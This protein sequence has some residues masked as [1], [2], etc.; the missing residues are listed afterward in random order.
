MLNPD[1]NEA[2]SQQ[3]YTLKKDM[4]RST[5]T[6]IGGQVTSI[7]TAAH[8]LATLLKA[9][10][11]LNASGSNSRFP[12]VNRATNALSHGTGA[13]AVNNWNQAKT[14]ISE[15]FAKLIKGG[16]A[17][18]GEID[19]IQKNLDASLSPRQRNDAIAQAAQFLQGR[20]GA[21]EE[22][23]NAVL[24][25]MAAGKPLMTDESRRVFE[26]T[27]KLTAKPSGT[28]YMRG[29]IVNHGGKKYR[30]TGGDPTNPDLEEVR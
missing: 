11:A 16:V 7:N 3:A 26:A 10:E 12:M 25:D 18:E 5:P 6:S 24:G 21:I 27:Q 22:H 29:Q 15:E 28:Q 8:H 4:G 14:F 2:D 17:T 19:A 13:S 1:F 30:V 23:R 9:N 20:I